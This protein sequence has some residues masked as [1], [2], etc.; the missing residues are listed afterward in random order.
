M[1]KKKERDLT[2][3]ELHHGILDLVYATDIRSY[4]ELV[5]ILESVKVDFAEAINFV[6]EVVEDAEEVEEAPP[7]LPKKKSFWEMLG[8]GKKKDM[9]FR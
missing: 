1:A 9:M 2:P 4:Y 3:G 7:D 8:G 6:G 5:G